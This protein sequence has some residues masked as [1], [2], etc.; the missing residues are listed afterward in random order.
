MPPKP[1]DPATSS[2]E[3]ETVMATPSHFGLPIREFKEGGCWK[4]YRALLGDI[5]ESHDITD[6]KKK[7]SLLMSYCGEFLNETIR[8][9]TTPDEPNT[10]SFEEICSLVKAHLQ[11]EPTIMIERSKFFGLWRRDG[12]PMLLWETRVRDGARQCG[13]QAAV[14]D[15]N[16]RDRFVL[17]IRHERI[18]RQLIGESTL[19]FPKAVEL[20]K[21][22]EATMANVEAL[23]ASEPAKPVTPSTEVSENVEVDFVKRQKRQTHVRTDHSAKCFRCLGS[24]SGDIC[25]FKTATCHKC[26]K[27]GHLSR[28]C[29]S[30]SS[31]HV[32]NIEMIDTVN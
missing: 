30:T 4:R 11:P 21:R 23:T 32:Q 9:L 17:G 27:V 15:E 31:E 6:E 10:K 2:A 16:L 3:T 19:T 13:F 5:Y 24:H 20:A 22:T 12:E 8:M 28:C 1:K 29:K 14:L 25:R 26:N 18:Q 7:R